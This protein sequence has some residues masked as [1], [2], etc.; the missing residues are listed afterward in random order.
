MRWEGRR[1]GGGDRALPHAAAPQ[2]DQDLTYPDPSAGTTDAIPRLGPRAA[3][4]SEPILGSGSIP[5]TRGWAFGCAI[6]FH[7]GPKTL[8][9][10]PGLMECL[11]P[12]IPRMV[13][14][15]MG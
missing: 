15:V 13:E 4:C 10:I 1:E 12:T 7:L 8:A 2:K 9:N 11:F 3:K 14:A 6:V 5:S